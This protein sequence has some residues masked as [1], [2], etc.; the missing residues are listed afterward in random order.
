MLSTVT[1]L[2]SAGLVVSGS[3]QA[4]ASQT[5]AS[6]QAAAQPGAPKQ[7]TGTPIDVDFQ[8]AD[9]RTVLR[10]IAQ[11]GGF[12]LVIDP[13]V[14]SSA[15]VDLKL[16]QVPWDQA[17]DIVLATSGLEAEVDGT[18]VRV[19]SSAAREKELKARSA[20]L[21]A[22]DE[23][24]ARASVTQPKPFTLKYAKGGDLQALLKAPGVLSKYANV[25]FDTRTNKL[26]V[27]GLPKDIET[28]ENLIKQL[29][30]P[31]PQVEIEAQI[32][33]TD[34]DSARA[35]GIQW[36]FNGRA[37]SEL[38]N[39][40]PLGFPNNGSLGG[41][42]GQQQGPAAGAGADPRAS[43]LEKTGSAVNLPVTAPTS[44]IGLTLGAINGA[45]NIDVAL[46]ALQ[47][48]G[49]VHILSTPKVMT[50]NNQ[51][52]E[53]TT[54]FQV[55]F[56]TISNNTVVIQFRDAALKLTVKPQI[57][58]DA[59]TVVMNIVLENGFPD[60]SR[61]VNGNP[62]INT[63]RATTQVLVPDGVTTVIGGI[64]QSTESVKNDQTPG[65]GNLPLL[66]WLFKRN[67]NSSNSQELLIFITPRIYRGRP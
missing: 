24:Y 29:D 47:H 16:S 17:F 21:E 1:A 14:E 34:H 42:V 5:P 62:S 50:Q 39:T 67:E 12:N 26:V 46:S 36:G 40:L 57:I 53:V 59:N 65:I 44:A 61:A 55:P 15:K 49:Q 45:F 13:T 3:P 11:T 19:V 25:Q 33:E 52:A 60:F 58:V 27:S 6:P 2:L 32:V 38:G 37:T 30:D 48:K 4:P 54:G 8:G 64:K 63:Q 35:L 43:A 20:R 28:A 41:R 7:Y 51:E 31:Q 22:Q 9:L 18:V 66:G 56:Q 23:N 10:L